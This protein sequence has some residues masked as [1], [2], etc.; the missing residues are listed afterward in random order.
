MGLWIVFY[1]ARNN[2]RTHIER[3]IN[4]LRILK[5]EKNRTKRRQLIPSDQE[6]TDDF[7]AWLQRKESKIGM[8][9]C[10]Y[11]PLPTPL[12]NW[13]TKKRIPFTQGRINP[14]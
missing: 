7:D 8:H 13:L 10:S 5:N 14:H 1:N 6:I 11:E 12:R 3:K 9:V 2:G 4:Q